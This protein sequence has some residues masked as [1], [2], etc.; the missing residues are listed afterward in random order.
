VTIYTRKYKWVCK[1]GKCYRRVRVVSDT[2]CVITIEGKNYGVCKYLGQKVTKPLRVSKYKP[3][4]LGQVVYTLK[5]LK[6][7][8][9]K[10]SE[11]DKRMIDEFISWL[12]H[13]FYRVR[14][15]KTVKENV[16]ESN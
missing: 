7:G 8:K 15:M 6:E 4:P 13:R 14:L 16:N 3:L 5:Y 11:L 2:A 9:M 10:L 12:G 1:R